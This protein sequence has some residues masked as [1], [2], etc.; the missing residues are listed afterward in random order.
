VYYKWV[1]GEANVASIVVD[2]HEGWVTSLA[3]ETAA[4]VFSPG[5]I[6]EIARR[7][8]RP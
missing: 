4:F 1:T 7:P 5:S 2:V 3:Y 8:H 6:R